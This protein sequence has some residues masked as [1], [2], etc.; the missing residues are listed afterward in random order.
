MKPTIPSKP[1]VAPQP[2]PAPLPGVPSKPVTIPA[3]QAP[4]PAQRDAAELPATVEEIKSGNKPVVTSTGRLAI[5]IDDMGTSMQE[6]RSLADIGVPL[7]FSIIPGLRSYRDVAAFAAANA[8]ETMIHIPM[9]SKGWPQRRLESNGL[10]LSMTD[11]DI[12]AHLEEFYRTIPKAVGANNHM[13]SEFTEHEDKMRVVLD[14]LRLRGLFFVD[15]VTS[16][17]TAGLRVAR[18]LGVRSARRNVFLDNE[19]NDSYIRGQLAQA[20]ALARKSGAAIA[21]CHPHPVTLK[22]LAVVLPT[23]EAQGVKL[24]PASAMVH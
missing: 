20:V 3:D 1:Q 8:I 6:A 12:R 10:L 11:D 4:P 21:I 7:T 24:V 2:L 15:S 17:Q 22:T 23:L 18:E 9:Q 13:G 14:T 19:Q 16:P 5:I